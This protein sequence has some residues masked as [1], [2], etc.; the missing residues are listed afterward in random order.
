M[1][2]LVGLLVEL[3]GLVILVLRPILGLDGIVLNCSFSLLTDA[4]FNVLI[5]EGGS[6][7]CNNLS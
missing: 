7:K 2:A 4:F 6:R 3:E 1:L 5:A